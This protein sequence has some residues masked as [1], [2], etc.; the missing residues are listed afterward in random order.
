VTLDSPQYAAAFDAAVESARRHGMP[1]VVR[2]R[3]A[4]VIET[5]ARIAGSLL[6]PWRTD[7]AS[8]EQAAENTLAFQRRRARFEFSTAEFGRRID[9]AEP[10]QAGPDV[11]GTEPSA[12]DLTQ[13][14]GSLELRVWVFIERAQTP[15]LRRSTWTR[16]ATTSTRIIDPNG[17]QSRGSGTVWAPLTRD[18]DYERRLLAEVEGSLRQ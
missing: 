6:E 14:Q 9:P 16:S 7:H 5:E 4:G 10:R 17:D 12:G 11:L 1:A 3:R 15:G 8:V 13:T 2:D 18:K